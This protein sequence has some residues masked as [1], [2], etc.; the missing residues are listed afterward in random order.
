MFLACFWFGCALRLNLN[1]F[2]STEV[3]KGVLKWL[4]DYL[5]PLIVDYLVNYLMRMK[6]TL[7]FRMVICRIVIQHVNLP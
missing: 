3:L 5:S 4:V 7:P 2:G 6:D 1:M